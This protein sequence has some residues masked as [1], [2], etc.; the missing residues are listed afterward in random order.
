MRHTVA[1]LYAL[2]QTGAV[3]CLQVRGGTGRLRFARIQG[4]V[5]SVSVCPRGAVPR[6][7]RR[8]AGRGCFCAPAARARRQVSAGRRREVRPRSGGG[9]RSR[10]ARAQRGQR[11]GGRRATGAPTASTWA[12]RQAAA[13][14][15]ARACALAVG[16]GSIIAGGL[17]SGN[18]V[19]SQW[20]GDAQCGRGAEEAR[21]V[22]AESAGARAARSRVATSG[23]ACPCSP[24][25]GSG[26]SSASWSL[27]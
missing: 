17:G 9:A 20:K 21:V 13:L 16:R 6:R 27:D 24:R 18:G 7:W 2:S 19:G 4:R 22:G 26:P 5:S 8:T 1:G 10:R 23:G 11:G 3:Q 14:C 25:M 15:A 12:F